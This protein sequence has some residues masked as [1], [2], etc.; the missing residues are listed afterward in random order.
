MIL[1]LDIF[2]T[3][4]QK[5]KNLK[6]SKRIDKFI[7]EID[8][9]SDINIVVITNGNLQNKDLG[10]YVF[11]L[12][13]LSTSELEEDYFY[14][15][16][17]FTK[18][19]EIVEY[20]NSRRKLTNL[21]GNANDYE[22]E[23]PVITY[24]SYKGGMG[25]ST[26][27]V[28][29]ATHLARHFG[30]KVV[31][32]DCDFEAPGFSNFFLENPTAPKYHNG[33]IEYF[34]DSEVDSEI[35]LN[36]Y[37]WEVS[38][39]YSKDGEI[40]IIPA[41]NL[42]IESNFVN[43]LFETD[44]RH[45]LEGLS[46]LDFSST[47]YLVEKFKK[48]IRDVKNQFEPDVIFIDSR[49]GFTDVFGIVALKLASHVVGFFSNSAQ[50]EPGLYQFIDSVKTI[51]DI[52]NEFRTIIVNAF[53]TP[54]LFEEFKSKVENY[55]LD[56][57]KENENPSIPDFYYFS[58]DQ[59][60]ALMGTSLEEKSSWLT[61]VDKERIGEPELAK[62]INFLVNEYKKV[63]QKVSLNFEIEQKGHQVI[64][65]VTD[66]DSRKIQNKILTQLNDNWPNLYADNSQ[67]DF[68]AEF[69]EGKIY[70]RESMKDIF[71]FDKF[72]VLGNKGTGKSYLFQ[73]LKNS[74]ITEELKRQAQKNHLNIQFIHLVDKKDN[75]FIST[76]FFESYRSE[77]ENIGNFYSKFWKVYT[78]R[79]IIDKITK[80]LESFQST[81]SCDFS[82]L[83]NENE[84]NK[85]VKFVSNIENIISVEK[86][87]EE[88]DK[89]LNSKQIDVVAIYDNLDLMVE[90]VSWKDQM[91]P[92]INFWNYSNYKRIHSKLFLRSDL[93]KRIVGV[94][95][96]QAL[97]NNII[98][99]E[100]RK[101]EIFNYFFNLVKLYAKQDFIRALEKFDF[102][103]ISDDST[104]W[105]ED[106]KRSFNASSNKQK[107]FDEYI[108]RRLCWVFFG[109]YPDVKKDHGESYD[110]L[111]K[112][113]MNADE[114]IS[115]RP[116]IDLLKLSIMEYTKDA[117]KDSTSVLPK[118]YYTSREVRKNAVD[119]HFTDL[120]VEEGNQFLKNIFD[121]IND[122]VE[123]QYYEFLQRDFYSLLDEVIKEDNL[124]ATIKDL[125][126]L[127]I[128]SG[129]VR[130]TPIPG[131]AKYSFAFL[132][133]Y[134]LGLGN[135]KKGKR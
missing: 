13:I 109:Q 64:E 75:Y 135:R 85:I 28:I 41:G 132:Y 76:K 31:I 15:D 23:I 1:L 114:T 122:H 26:N 33:V 19:D 81:I 92:L 99:I 61:L 108:L 48:L 36:N 71:N 43:D 3:L 79:T 73:A 110:W 101:E 34:F 124:N 44:L 66:I 82:V 119:N 72:I 93:Y 62:K 67:I 115:L 128:I 104:S 78:W 35:N 20:S 95:N 129:I 8:Q 130:R 91:A 22:P 58:Y 112:N 83:N 120:V 16:Q 134:R 30:K 50:N 116:F 77:I 100:W 6:D 118:K 53:S 65:L 60:L 18:G 46:R 69:D 2:D 80:V 11:N 5:L 126:E 51:P 88:I 38:K 59:E 24:Y 103:S 111:Y 84:T 125:E 45:Y 63:K 102:V 113:V 121:Y 87:L 86:E 54:K 12:T 131:N 74:N 57:Y 96:S 47:E 105:V 25:R 17:F 21:L 40:R 123:Y 4:V 90:P 9:R 70:Y 42:A 98:S 117:Y 32:I 89:Q 14:N 39:E 127:L 107:E 55:I 106:V 37:S 49:T 94:N 52:K 7:I 10:D 97:K 68:Q 56:I 27:L 133:K 29:T